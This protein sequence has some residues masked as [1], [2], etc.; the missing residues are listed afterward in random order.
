MSSTK[1]NKRKRGSKAGINSTASNRQQ[2]AV[3]PDSAQDNAITSS[4]STADNVSRS[5]PI[6]NNIAI[7]PSASDETEASS[8][9]QL[10]TEAREKGGTKNTNEQVGVKKV[11]EPINNDKNNEKEKVDNS[12]S[13]SSNENMTD[14]KSNTNSLDASS[15]CSSSEDGTST[16]RRHALHT[17]SYDDDDDD[18]HHRR[19]KRMQDMILHRSMLLERVKSCRSSAEKRIGEFSSKSQGNNN[20][21]ELTDDEEIAAFRNMTKRANQA[22]RKNN[23]GDGDGKGGTNEKRTSLSLRRGSNIGKRMNAA[24]SSLV[25]G[26]NL[27]TN[28]N[29]N[30]VDSNDVAAQTSVSVSDKCTSST[31]SAIKVSPSSKTNISSKGTRLPVNPIGTS[32]TTTTNTKT[33]V[34]PN[35]SNPKLNKVTPYPIQSTKQSEVPRPQPRGRPPN[36]KNNKTSNKLSGQS[37]GSQQLAPTSSIIARTDQNTNKSAGPTMMTTNN[38]NPRSSLA[39]AS[40]SSKVHFPEAILLRE[41]RDQIQMKLRNLMERQQHSNDPSIMTMSGGGMKSNFDDEAHAR[42]AVTT[43]GGV[44][45][46]PLMKKKIN[47]TTELEI[48]SPAQLPQRRKTHWDTLLQEMSWLASDFMEERKW[49][50]STAR[51]IS[52][53]IP[54]QGISSDR[55]KRSAEVISHDASRDLHIDNIALS[56]S[57]LDNPNSSRETKHLNKKDTRRRYTPPAIEDENIAKSNS[58]ILSCMISELDVAIKQGGSFEVSDKYHQA[59]LKQFVS[60]RSDILEKLTAIS[61]SKYLATQNHPNDKLSPIKQN[62]EDTTSTANTV[63]MIDVDNNNKDDSR[64]KDSNFDS[65]NDYI[66]NIHNVCRSRY[67]SSTRESTT[68]SLKSGNIKLAPKQKEMI[69]FVDKV[70]S[71]K[72]C[73]SAMILGPTISGKTF[74]TATIIW[75][76]RTKGP[77][78][79]IC[80]PRSMVSIQ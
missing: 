40:A 48:P 75:K 73:T 37:G 78:L 57:S 38:F 63:D 9:S 64:L 19:E 2:R 43:A 54:A 56:A 45:S 7:E 25:P 27:T 59:A 80:P 6:T 60:T 34:Q 70:W 33:V 8:S 12:S 13:S 68:K 4:T 46:K 11:Q 69:D 17:A 53:K 20:N 65:I 21:N 36:S 77:Q 35:N 72:P 10:T 14:K 18:N 23:R 55:R 30:A 71:G 16:T 5:T 79:L 3:A 26:S 74:A 51:L 62:D 32:T 24:L 1:N 41:K 49:K 39:Q 61:T 58:Q 22:A 29:A 31:K 44:T 67:K 52:S 76:Q 47:V 50:L 28:A 42:R 15:S 66:D